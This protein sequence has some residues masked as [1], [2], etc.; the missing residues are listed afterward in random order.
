IYDLAR[1]QFNERELVDLTLAIVAINGWN[2]LSVAFRKEAGTYDPTGAGS[3]PRADE[4]G[5]G[6]HAVG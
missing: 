4:P 3:S 6:F 5:P 1:Q 2:R